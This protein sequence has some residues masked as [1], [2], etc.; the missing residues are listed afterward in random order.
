M[1]PQLLRETSAAYDVLL[2]SLLHSATSKTGLRPWWLHDQKVAALA[3]LELELRGGSL[4]H[5]YQW[6]DQLARKVKAAHARLSDV[7]RLID[8]NPAEF[9]T[10]LLAF[11]KLTAQQDPNVDLV[12]QLLERDTFDEIDDIHRKANDRLHQLL[13]TAAIRRERLLEPKFR[14]MLA[15]VVGLTVEEANDL[16]TE[17]DQVINEAT[18]KVEAAKDALIAAERESTDAS[19][20]DNSNGPGSGPA[21]SSAATGSTAGGTTSQE[22]TESGQDTASPGESDT[23][24]MRTDPLAD[25]QF[26][27]HAR[28]PP[29]LW[30]RLWQQFLNWLRNHTRPQPRF[31]SAVVQV[32]LALVG[33]VAVL[34]LLARHSIAAGDGTVT[35]SAA[36]LIPALRHLQSALAPWNTRPSKTST[37]PGHTADL[38]SPPASGHRMVGGSRLRAAETLIVRVPASH[39]HHARG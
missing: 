34:A 15:R 8:T 36:G 5:I 26:T 21:T 31:A 1:T 20:S 28:D 14:T 38:P 3:G 9:I 7:E 12:I 16:L 35:M 24:E 17:H 23:T 13:L 4:T 37:T 10:E 19:D 33:A 32:V 27:N 11:W 25:R 22:A 2:Q 39:D 6:R 30:Q 29:A 18:A